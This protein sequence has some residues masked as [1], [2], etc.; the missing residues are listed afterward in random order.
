M[1]EILIVNQMILTG[2]LDSENT[3]CSVLNKKYRELQKRQ[4]KRILFNFKIFLFKACKKRSLMK[5]ATLF[6]LLSEIK[7]HSQSFLSLL[8]SYKSGG[9]NQRG[10]FV[11]FFGE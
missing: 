7:E 3:Y 2:T 10:R 5:L 8:V 1:C 9:G 6:C 11:Q 4:Y